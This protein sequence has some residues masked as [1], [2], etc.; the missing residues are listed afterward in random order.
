VLTVEAPELVGDRS[1]F[2]ALPGGRLLVGQGSADPA[3]LASAVERE[4]EPPYR[5]EAVRQG[6]SLWAVGARRIVVFELP[7]T[8]ADV[9]EVTERNGETAVRLDGALTLQRPPDGLR[10]AV[11]GRFGEFAAVATR[12]EGDLFEL[13]VTPL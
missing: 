6:G 11:E 13:A 1:T 8:P 9:V 3:A 2:T 5:A 4:L 10:E 7:D 12:L